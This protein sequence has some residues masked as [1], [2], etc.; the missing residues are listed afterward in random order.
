M[1]IN[2]FNKRNSKN[3][4]CLSQDLSSLYSA[5]LQSSTS[6][7]VNTLGSVS[8]ILDIEDTRHQVPWALRIIN[9][10]RIIKNKLLQYHLVFRIIDLSFVYFSQC[11]FLD[12]LCLSLNYLYLA[13]YLSL[14]RLFLISISIFLPLLRKGSSLSISL[15]ISLALN[16]YLYRSRFREKGALSV[17]L[18]LYL[19][20]SISLSFYLFL[21]LYI[22][23]SLFLSLPFFKSLSLSL[24]VFLSP[25]LFLAQVAVHLRIV[26]SN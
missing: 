5:N 17:Y 13:L 14:S 23:I 26:P 8:H 16:L 20:L 6:P 7:N 4:I 9:K 12:N 1:N 24:S 19:S 3:R 11:T 2:Q 25:F 21:S 18:S 10:L 15:S 22:Y